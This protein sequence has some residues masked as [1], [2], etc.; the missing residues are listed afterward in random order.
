M[1][2]A[3]TRGAQPDRSPEEIRD[4]I[5]TTREE[6]GDTVE[7]LAAKTD[8][9]ARAQAKADEL[10]TDASRRAHE[11]LEA[12]RRNPAPIAAAGLVLIT[13]FIWTR[14]GR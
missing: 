7:E 9:K 1:S 8:V 11:G 5:E 13:A 10:K 4:D 14:R 3:T 6:L 12:A 2:D